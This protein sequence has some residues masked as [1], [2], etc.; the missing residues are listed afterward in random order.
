[1]FVVFSIRGRCDDRGRYGCRWD[2]CWDHYSCVVI[3]VFVVI[4]MIVCT[5]VVVAVALTGVVMIVVV[6]E[7]EVLY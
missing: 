1:M 3:V 5:L 2:Y 7:F 6:V 4:F